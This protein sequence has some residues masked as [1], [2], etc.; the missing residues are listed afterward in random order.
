MSFE[1]LAAV[2]QLLSVLVLSSLV[3][4]LKRLAASSDSWQAFPLQSPLKCQQESHHNLASN[5][6][7]GG[8]G[9]EPKCMN[10]VARGLT[11]VG[12]CCLSQDD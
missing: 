7:T 10:V 3:H 12:K 6:S 9:L 4:V 5:K 8:L 11:N 1:W 2:V